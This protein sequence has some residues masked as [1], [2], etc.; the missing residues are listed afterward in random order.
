MYSLLR[1][2]DDY[3]E[4]LDL[5]FLPQEVSLGHP[6]EWVFPSDVIPVQPLQQ[7]E[8]IHQTHFCPLH[9]GLR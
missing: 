5:L 8:G 7:I 4:S 2:I 9:P 3:L 6:W 1:D